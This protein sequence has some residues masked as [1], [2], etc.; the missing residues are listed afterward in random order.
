M[1]P[2][3]SK[4]LPQEKNGNRSTSK[5]FERK[6]SKSKKPFQFKA[7]GLGKEDRNTVFGNT[8][9][10]N[11][12]ATTM[13]FTRE[14]KKDEGYPDFNNI[15][16]QN[17]DMQTFNDIIG[18][19]EI[20]FSVRKTHIPPTTQAFGPTS[21]LQGFKSSSNLKNFQSKPLLDNDDKWGDFNLFA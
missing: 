16:E 6:A 15:N 8:S 1:D 21:K 19:Q 2:W 11:T 12:T 7:K 3:G 14:L 10:S 13:A 20:E 9:L 4:Q 5:P 18:E 17:T